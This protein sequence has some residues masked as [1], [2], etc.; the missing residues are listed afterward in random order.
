MRKILDFQSRINETAPEDE[1]YGKRIT[2]LPGARVASGEREDHFSVEDRYHDNPMGYHV[3]NGGETL[4][5]DVW[6]DPAKRKKIFEYCP[7]LVMI[8]P[9]KLE[10]ERCPGDNKMGQ[11]QKEGQ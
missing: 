2:L 3:R 6:K 1:W 7:E 9:M 10:R 8:M 11:I 5:D 4:P